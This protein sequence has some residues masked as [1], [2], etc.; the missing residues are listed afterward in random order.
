MVHG[1]DAA[2][3]VIDEE[4]ESRHVGGR[5][6]CLGLRDYAIRRYGLLAKTVLNHWGLTQTEDF[7][8]IVFALVDAGLLRKTDDDTLEDFEGVFRFRRRVRVARS[9][10]RSTPPTD[11]PDPGDPSGRWLSA[12]ACSGTV[13]AWQISPRPTGPSMSTTAPR[14]A[15]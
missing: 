6:L 13:S 8:K 10:T 7:G 9:R 14:P 12:R 1:E 5:D 3:A 15:P 2:T 4:D 11:R